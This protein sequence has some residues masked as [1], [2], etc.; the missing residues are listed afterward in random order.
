MHYIAIL[1]HVILS[2]DIHLSGLTDG[3]L[4]AK[5]NIIVIFDYFGTD[6]ALL[7]VGMDYSGAFWSL[8]SAQESPGPYFVLTGSEECLQI[9][10]RICRAD[11]TR[12]ARLLQTD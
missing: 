11:K 12:H 1:H 9:K 4:A 5:L 3:S 7:E 6:K 10:K 8:A 2:F